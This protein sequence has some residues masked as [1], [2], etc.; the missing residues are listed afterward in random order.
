[1]LVTG[2]A[3]LTRLPPAIGGAAPGLVFS[4]GAALPF[5]A[6]QA[7]RRQLRSLPIEIL[8]S[9][10][11]GGVAWRR[12]ENEDA[13]WS[14][15]PG[16]RIEAGDGDR[17]CVRSPFTDS[18]KAV[19]TGD[20][21][22]RLGEKFR[23]KGRIDRVAKI[24]GKR[25][26]L[27]RVEEALL[28]QPIVEAAAAVRLPERR[29]ALGAVVELNPEGKAALVEKGAFR[30]SRDLRHALA[31]R[32]EPAERPKHWRF[33][34]IPFDRQGKRV[35]DLLRAVFDRNADEKMGR[36]SIREIEAEQSTICVELTPDMVWFEGHFPDQPV[37][38]GIA[39]VHM[40]VL[41]AQQVWGWRPHGGN[42]SQLKFRRVLRPG[43]TVQLR[44][45]RRLNQ[46]RLR[47]SYNLDEVVA[48]EGIIGGSA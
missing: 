8:G 47:F 23:L 12:Q 25:V 20:L 13:L 29:G 44:L 10:E 37:L 46:Q 19:S 9:T 34:A 48:S 42:V 4:S 22:D 38:A 41:W 39:Q 33:G 35:E 17:L 40:A 30:L 2:P 26:S 1:T 3:H 6:A 31:E 18:D 32:L 11:T 14:P 28:A 7:A 43:D 24:D 27:A 21:F 5:A 16:V 45:E 36:G 15:L